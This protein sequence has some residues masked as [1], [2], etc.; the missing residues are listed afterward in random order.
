MN[1]KILIGMM[2]IGINVTMSCEAYS[3]PQSRS[4]NIILTEALE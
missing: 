1:K 3:F 2:I 4:V